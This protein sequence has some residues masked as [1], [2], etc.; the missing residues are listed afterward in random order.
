MKANTVGRQQ[1]EMKEQDVKRHP[2]ALEHSQKNYLPGNLSPF[3]VVGGEVSVFFY[4]I[5]F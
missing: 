4:S 2:K 5:W 3:F 1:K